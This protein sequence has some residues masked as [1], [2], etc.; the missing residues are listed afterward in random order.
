VGGTGG[1]MRSGVG[2]T[3]W[4]TQAGWFLIQ[5]LQCLSQKLFPTVNV[6]VVQTLLL[7]EENTKLGPLH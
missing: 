1:A 7:I 6:R 3:A 4:P 5:P 2:V